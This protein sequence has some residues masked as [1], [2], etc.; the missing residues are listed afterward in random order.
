LSAW[1]EAEAS[2]ES[3]K[4]LHSGVASILALRVYASLTSIRPSTGLWGI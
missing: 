4:G 1:P 3:P 2:L